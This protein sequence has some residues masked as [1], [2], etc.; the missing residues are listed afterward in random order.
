MIL[1]VESNLA[2]DALFTNALAQFEWDLA[3][4]GWCVLSHNVP[5]HIDSAWDAD[6]QHPN[7]QYVADRDLIK[8]IIVADYSAAPAE[9]KAVIILGH[10]TVPIS[11]WHNPDNHGSRALPANPYY[12]DVDGIWTDGITFGEAVIR[13][14]HPAEPR[15]HN[16]ANDG[17]CDPL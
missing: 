10:V 6:P 1:L 4:D 3:G 14:G 2:S 15:H 16:Y 9:T 5:R 17:K 11:G 13:R 7:P 12:G 8:S